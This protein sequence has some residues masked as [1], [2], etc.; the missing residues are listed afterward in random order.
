MNARGVS[1]FRSRTRCSS[2]L[3]G[4]IVRN[5]WYTPAV[6][7]HV[8]LS[9]CV[10][11]WLALTTALAANEPLRVS[12][13]AT[14][15]DVLRHLTSAEHRGKVIA[16]L[17]PLQVSRVFL[18]G[19]RGDEYVPPS[20]MVEVRDF[21]AAQGIRS[22]GGIATVPGGSF[23]VRQDEH[24]KNEH[25]GWHAANLS[26]LSN[27]RHTEMSEAKFFRRGNDRYMKE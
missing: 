13:Y 10:A 24:A 18:E 3:R 16:A 23:G 2:A 22:A 25:R 15:G 17:K 4:T 27:D 11:G 7:H 8:P 9:L 26:Q 6:R 12:V 20:T 14:A 1:R 21:L 19:R 5:F